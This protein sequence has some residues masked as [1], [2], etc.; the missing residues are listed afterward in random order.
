L[1][2]EEYI[3]YF[4]IENGDAASCRMTDSRVEIDWQQDRGRRKVKVE[5]QVK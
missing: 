5:A 3:E 1:K 2:N 4:K